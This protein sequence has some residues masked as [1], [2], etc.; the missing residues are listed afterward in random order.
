[1]IKDKKRLQKLASLSYGSVLDIG[2]NDNPNLFLVDPIGFDSSNSNKKKAQNYK[3]I[4]VGDCQEISLYFPPLSFDTIIAG[5]IIE[6]LEHPAKFLRECKKILKDDGV[7]LI[8]TPN[9]YNI[10]TIIANVLFI[11]RGV[12]P[13]HINLFPYRNMIAL[14]NH[15]ELECE[16]V[17]DAGGGTKLIPNKPSLLIPMIKSFCWQLLYIVKKRY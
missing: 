1:M 16:K 15:V 9:P 6:H 14:L 8:T 11:E 12:A 17:L 5:E 10:T 3:N 2:F 7:L 4:I 13:G